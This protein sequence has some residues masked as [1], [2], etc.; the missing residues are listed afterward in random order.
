MRE[1]GSVSIL[2]VMNSAGRALL[3]IAALLMGLRAGSAAAREPYLQ[4]VT[5][6]AALL[7]VTTAEGCSVRVLL[8]EVDSERNVGEFSSTSS[9]PRHPVWL[10]GLVPG[11]AYKYRV[12]A[13]GLLA[14]AI[15]F[16]SAPSPGATFQFAA[17]GD[18]GDD[19]GSRTAMIG[20]LEGARLDLLLALGD[21]A[22]VK[23][24]EQEFETNFF[25]PL[26]RLLASVPV[27]P[28]LGNHE[29][30]TNEGQPYLDNFF[31]PTNNP[32]QSE[33]Y[34]S[35]DWGDAHF[36]ALD[37]NCVVGEAAPSSCTALEQREWLSA[38]LASAQAARWRIV[39]LHH[40]PWSSGSHGSSA[41]VRTAFES[42]WEEGKVDLVLAGHDHNYE[43]SVPLLR[44]QPATDGGGVTYIVA[45]NG[46]RELRPFDTSQPAWSAVRKD[47]DHGFLE[48]TI[49]PSL[50]SGRMVT[51]DN[52][53]VDAFELIKPAPPPPEDAGT[54]EMD[55][56]APDPEPDLSSPPGVHAP[57]ASAPRS[58]GHGCAAA[59]VVT[60]L[61]VLLP[62]LVRARRR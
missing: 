8:S 30:L 60:L 48:I 56:G 55:A 49:T 62:A 16:R 37:S 14:P 28:T 40:P 38:D 58:C 53:V 15:T 26:G 23:G 61:A 51:S 17:V 21:N 18:V 57:D 39:F 25:T 59:P 43:R 36:V 20:V 42:I 3:V 24:T 27:F 4:Q 12:E 47:Q 32:R 50:L 44:G 7:V 33:R 34:Y 19:S 41:D 35:F 1:G 29:Y 2:P 13:C 45:G 52:V 10:T 31:L 6:T 11:G 46:G 54:N 22:Y 9:G 5:G